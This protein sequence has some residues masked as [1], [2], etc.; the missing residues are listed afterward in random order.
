MPGPDRVGGKR[1]FFISFDVIYSIST[2]FLVIIIGIIV[3]LYL[4]KRGREKN[5]RKQREK[6][7]EE[8]KPPGE[9]EK[10]PHH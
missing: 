3:K 2:L 5:L 1:S 8:R 10:L 6:S 4:G 9:E 7:S